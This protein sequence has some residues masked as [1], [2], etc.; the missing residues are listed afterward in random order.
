MPTPRGVTG[1]TRF[2]L[3]LDGT[4]AGQPDSAQGG[5]AVG[6]VVVDPAGPDGIQRKHLEGLHYTDIVLTCGT[7]M[8]PA[9]W[10]WISDSFEGK[11]ELRDGALRV[12]D[13]DRKERERVEFTNGLVT[14]IGFP[15]FD[16][17]S[18]DGF[19]LTVR[20]VAE[21]VRR[22]RGDGATA[23]GSIKGKQSLVSNFEVTLTGL[24]LKRANRVGPLTIR[25]DPT[26]GAWDVPDLELTL[27]EAGS[28]SVVDWHKA[29]VIDGR[30][31]D[32]DEK[33][34]S[35]SL[36]EPAGKKSLLQIE[37]AGVGIF[38]LEREAGS[39]RDTIAALTARMYCE[40]LRLVPPG[41]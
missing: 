15:A 30:N 16:G 36:L 25:R 12:L 28:E 13:F 29:F 3:E 39:G 24:D 11:Y 40:Q 18:K 38:A 20:I 35:I 4:P 22:Q 14:E 5:D 27:S 31:G 8:E 17:A 37:L 10:T 41:K 2:A 21:Q 32:A 23:A 6:E 33:S 9:F 7:G 1:A 19:E 34:G 26:P